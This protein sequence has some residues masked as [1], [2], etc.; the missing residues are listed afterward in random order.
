MDD[1]TVSEI[2]KELCKQGVSL[3]KD[4]LEDIFIYGDEELA[5]RYLS[6]AIK[7]KEIQPLTG[8]MLRSIMYYTESDTLAE[9]IKT[10]DKEELTFDILT[11]VI[12]YLDQEEADGCLT[13][14]IQ[15][16]NTLTYSQYDRISYCLSDKMRQKIESEMKFK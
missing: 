16:G 6:E 5:G 2:L 13:Y 4:E 8:E 10:M 3:T 9:L 11:D 12:D 15:L 1:K 14:Y 7:N